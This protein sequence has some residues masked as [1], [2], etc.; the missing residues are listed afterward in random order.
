MTDFRCLVGKSAEEFIST[1]WVFSYT[2]GLKCNVEITHLYTN[3]SGSSKYE[4]C[5][6]YAHD[7]SLK[8]GMKLR[9][10]EIWTKED[11]HEILAYAKDAV[12]FFPCGWR[13]ASVT[14]SVSCGHICI[15]VFDKRIKL[16][17]IGD[18][19]TSINYALKSLERKQTEWHRIATNEGHKSK[20]NNQ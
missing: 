5:Q 9:E 20:D 6:L 10:L 13:D 2:A 19:S 15:E 18:W 4:D 3:I 11:C 17:L 16:L 12:T 8:S 7:T 14:I 1:L